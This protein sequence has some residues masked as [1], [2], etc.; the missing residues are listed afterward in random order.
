MVELY[1]EVTIGYK[2]R[3]TT[4]AQLSAVCALAFGKQ[5]GGDCAL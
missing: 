2:P 5:E 3:W 1:C 4:P